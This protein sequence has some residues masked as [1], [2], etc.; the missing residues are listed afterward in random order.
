MGDDELGTYT[1]YEVEV[2]DDTT[3]TGGAC[4]L[5]N[6]NIVVTMNRD[7]I[8]LANWNELNTRK[9]STVDWIKKG[10]VDIIRCGKCGSMK[11]IYSFLQNQ[12]L[13]INHQTIIIN[14]PHPNLM[15]RFFL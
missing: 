15:S 14:T 6:D 10:E 2:Y 1:I 7:K 13:I 9:L 12:Y 8:K 4:I 3:T 5:E 11:A